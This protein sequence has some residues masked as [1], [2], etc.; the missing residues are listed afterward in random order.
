MERVTGIEPA[1]LGWKPKVIPLYDTRMV[2][3]TG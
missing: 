1:S 3:A 2:E